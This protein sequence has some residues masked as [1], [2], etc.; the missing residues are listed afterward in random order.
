M[1]FTSTDLDTI[2][3]AI[4]SG[5]K[6]VR[7]AD[8]TVEYHSMEEMMRARELIMNQLGVNAGTSRVTVSQFS[9]GL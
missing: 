5:A 8:K 6:M 9:K 7:Y 1:A 3:A 2:N 4:A